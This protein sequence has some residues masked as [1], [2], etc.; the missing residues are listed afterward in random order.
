MYKRQGH[1]QANGKAESAVK[2]VKRMLKRTAHCHEDQFLA[3]LEMR[4]TPRQD[5]NLS[6]AFILFGGQTRSVIPVITKRCSNLDACKHHKRQK[7]V[8]R[9][10]DKH[11]RPLC[12][13]VVDQ[14]VY[15][16]HPD[17]AAHLAQPM[18]VC[19]RRPAVQ[20]L[21]LQCQDLWFDWY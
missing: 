17:T 14:Q 19:H 20:N 6:P 7:H 16:Q 8:K 3:L 2:S 11:T 15:F 18:G 5:V 21:N 9:C 1:Q 4:N 12:E 10:F 13:L